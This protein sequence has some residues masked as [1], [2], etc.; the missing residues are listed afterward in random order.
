MTIAEEARST[1]QWAQTTPV[2]YS[3]S[4]SVDAAVAMKKTAGRSDADDASG[5]ASSSSAS[6]KPSLPPILREP[7]L[8][9]LGAALK[10]GAFKRIIVMAGAGISVS[11]GIPDFRVSCTLW[12][13]Q[14]LA[15]HGTI[16][17]KHILFHGFICGCIRTVSRPCFEP[18]FLHSCT[19]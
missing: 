12:A 9:A 15:C 7:T 5:S 4:S 16:N 2:G 11:A 10:S 13:I 17:T 3:S 14:H 1:A 18:I 6:V 19:L 8:E